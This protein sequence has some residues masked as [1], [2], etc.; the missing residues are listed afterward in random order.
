[1][2]SVGNERQK[3]AGRHEVVIPGRPIGQIGN[4]PAEA[5]SPKRGINPVGKAPKSAEERRDQR[6]AK[7]GVFGRDMKPGVLPPGKTGRHIPVA[8]QGGAEVMPDPGV[9]PA[10]CHQNDGGQ[11]T[12]MTQPN[13]DRCALGK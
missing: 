1:M 6:F 4:A 5:I 10:A 3:I 9:M 13:R 8:D 2:S 11:R 7:P 12:E